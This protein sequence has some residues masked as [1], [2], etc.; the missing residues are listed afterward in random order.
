MDIELLAQGRYP[1]QARAY[2]NISSRRQLGDEGSEIAFSDLPSREEHVQRQ[3][4]F[5]RQDEEE[6]L[7]RILHERRARDQQQSGLSNRARRRPRL[8]W[9]MKELCQLLKLCREYGTQWSLIKEVDS[10]Q[11]SP[12]LENR[13]QVDLK[14]KAR[15]VKM[16]MM[17]NDMEVPENLEGIRLSDGRMELIAKHFARR[18]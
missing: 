15:N 4:A 2:R 9:S 7:Q 18:G 11:A 14:D 12:K 1:K 16:W 17:R 5:T 10:E 13:T 6:R 3:R 8:P